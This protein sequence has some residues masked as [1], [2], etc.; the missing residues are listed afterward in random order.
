MDNELKCSCGH[1]RKK[2]KIVTGGK[3][4]SIE[5]KNPHFTN[6]EIMVDRE[7][8]VKLLKFQRVI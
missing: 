8:L 3:S 7:E 2:L 4:I 6:M 5:I 1:C